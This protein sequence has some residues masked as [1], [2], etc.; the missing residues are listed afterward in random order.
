MICEGQLPG[1]KERN[2]MNVKHAVAEKDR[3]CLATGLWI[4]K[5][6]EKNNGNWE[7]RKQENNSNSR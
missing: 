6:G 2:F 1:V 3:V 7:E 5:R 4:N